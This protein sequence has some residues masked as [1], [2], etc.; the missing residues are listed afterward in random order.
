MSQI[1]SPSTARPI[2]ETDE[3]ETFNESDLSLSQ[4][5][6]TINSGE[7]RVSQSE[8]VRTV[9]DRN[10]STGTSSYQTVFSDSVTLSGSTNISYDITV[11]SSD[12]I[13]SGEVRLRDTTRGVTIAEGS[14]GPNAGTVDLKQTESIVSGSQTTVNLAF[15]VNGAGAVYDVQLTK[16]QIPTS[17]TAIVEWSEPQDVFR[18]DAITFQR[19][20]DVTVDIQHNDGSGWTTAKTD[21]DPGGEI[22][23]RPTDRVRF[24][25]QLQKVDTG[26]SALESIYRRWIVGPTE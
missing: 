17:G 20:G 5:A 14:Y 25:V 3:A 6:T 19:R 24:R 2:A 12:S 10:G 8:P 4:T 7:L 15:Q 18:W 23:A 11:E 16:N 13:S 21:V 9:F 1:T 22:E 26:T